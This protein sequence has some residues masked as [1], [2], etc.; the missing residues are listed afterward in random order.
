MEVAVW[1]DITSLQISIRCLKISVFSGEHAI[2]FYRRLSS[3]RKIHPL[4]PLPSDLRKL[5]GFLN[6]F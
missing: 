2:G 5:Y 3:G 6:S 4:L 1:E